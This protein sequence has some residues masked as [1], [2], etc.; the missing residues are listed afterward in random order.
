YGLYFM[1]AYYRIL[2]VPPDAMLDKIKKQWRLF[3]QAWHPDKFSNPTDKAIAE[4]KAKGFNE[5]YEVLSNPQRRKSYD[6][7]LQ[8]EHAWERSSLSSSPD[9]KYAEERRRREEA[10]AA[11]HRVQEE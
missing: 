4:E 6:M 9:V 3:V 5:A 8:T 11:L 1:K 10:E 7:Q 2:E